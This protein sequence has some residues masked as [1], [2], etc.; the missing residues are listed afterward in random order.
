MDTKLSF[1]RILSRLAFLTILFFAIFFPKVTS[2]ETA[3]VIEFFKS[4]V[5]SG[6]LIAL[7]LIVAVIWVIFRN[8]QLSP[9]FALEIEEEVKESRGGNG[10]A[11]APFSPTL[12]FFNLMGWINVK[13]PNKECVVIDGKKIISKT[14]WFFAPMRLVGKPMN[15]RRVLL[16]PDPLSVSEDGKTLD[17][18][19]LTLNTTISYRVIDPVYVSSLSD[20]LKELTDFIKGRIV[21]IIGKKDLV[22]LILNEND[23]RKELT[24]T[25]IRSHPVF[26]NYSACV[27]KIDP[28]GDSKIMEIKRKINEAILDKD[29]VSLEGEN[30]YLTAQYDLKVEQLK[31]QLQEDVKQRDFERTMQLQE[32]TA[33]YEMMREAFQAVAQVCAITVNPSSAIK[34]IESLILN[35][36]KQPEPILIDAP[37]KKLIDSEL[38]MLESVRVSFGITDYKVN[39]HAEKT[40][41]P[42]IARFEAKDLVIEMKCPANY[43]QDG[44][45]VCLVTPSTTKNLNISWFPNSNLTY[46]LSVGLT[47]AKLIQ[48]GYIQEEKIS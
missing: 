23:N 28:T 48:E 1:S 7:S 14:S 31:A 45:V 43:P 8:K 13:S 40:D 47:Q 6:W 3:P 4:R 42:G 38:E 20:P 44:P 37:K 30:T 34:E 12:T 21:E 35:V 2:S 16:N 27:I 46:A 18:Y 33:N 39:P 19:D 24:E 17:H 41:Q 5:F 32:M 25:L 36:R 11:S 15:A 26:D 9:D 10:L 29:R 22:A